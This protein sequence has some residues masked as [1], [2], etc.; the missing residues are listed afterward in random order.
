MTFLYPLPSTLYLLPSKTP[1]LLYPQQILSVTVLRHWLGQFVKLVEGYP[2]S[3]IGN[4]LKT[5]YFQA[6]ALFYHFDECRS[7]S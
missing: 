2:S 3:F 6:L 1:S 7:F 5:C 4:F